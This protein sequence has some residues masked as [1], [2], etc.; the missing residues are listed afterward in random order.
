MGC[1]GHCGQ[2]PAVA[3]ALLL[4]MNSTEEPILFCNM[5]S[6]SFFFF[7]RT[8]LFFLNLN[9][10]SFFLDKIRSRVLDCLIVRT[11]KN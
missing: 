11:I 6:R 5:N 9:S 7:F 8:I 10:M 3:E 1:Q 2:G 4:L